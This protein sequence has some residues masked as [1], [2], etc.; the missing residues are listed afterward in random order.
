[1]AYHLIITADERTWKF[2]QPVLFIGNW[3]C[4]YDRKKIWKKIDATV[5]SRYG[6]NQEQ[7]QS[8]H[9]KARI[10]EELLFPFL[11]E[12][13]NNY[14]EKK[15]S[16]RF[17]KI[18][19]G[20][21]FRRYIDFIVYQVKT[22]EWCFS[23]Y[24]ITSTTLLE[25]KQYNL[26]PLNSLEAISAFN[27]DRWKNLLCIELIKLM[28]LP[29]SID[30]ISIE[31]KFETYR[32]PA[33]H[34][35]E[36][37]KEQK[38]GKVARFLE[39]F[40][41]KQ[42]AFIIKSYLPKIDTLKLHLS[43][44]QMPQ[45]Y[46]F[47]NFFPKNKVDSVLRCN[48]SKQVVVDNTDLLSKVLGSMLFKLLPVCYL[49]GFSEL[50]K[51]MMKMPWPSEP[52]F[53]FTSNSFDFN[54]VF[55]LWTA[56]KVEEGY[57][58]I[59][60]QHGNNYGT[61]RYMNPSI[62]EITADKFLTW[63]WVDGLAQHTP[64]FILKKTKIK[65]EKYNKEGGL[66]L[67]EGVREL[68][69]STWDDTNGFDDYFKEQQD[70]VNGL[71]NKPKDSLVI[72]LHHGYRD[73]RCCEDLRWYDFDKTLKIETGRVSIDELIGQCRLTVHSYDSTGILEM[74]AQ[75]MP[76]IAFWQNDFDHLRESAKPYYQLLLDVGIIHLTP[77][78]ATKKINDI[79]DNVED[80]W[81]QAD[82]QQARQRF[83]NQYA[84][85]SNTPIKSLKTIFG[86]KV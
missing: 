80:W 28:E 19:L 84:Q 48:L 51:K 12:I 6:L 26:S 14:H 65:K 69:I 67:I 3:C 62:E 44:W 24:E 43:L 36:S 86:E 57:Q 82:V 49:E 74:L 9:K 55:K 81:A 38:S 70:F 45:V 61:H 71:K 4:L 73:F 22:L 53:I 5:A 30:K 20:H 78:S 59:T 64:S 56:T 54:E 34:T 75:N 41:K 25:S 32:N 66:L 42:D 17:W 29:V 76:T 31:D 72:R 79:W 85:V 60:G 27:E 68:N 33:L 35:E 15:Y 23:S 13:L 63:G 2:N 58:Y 40:V 46:K 47:Y 1:M 37:V 39:L 10:L 11:C 7:K 50:R 83:C 52:K 77:E 18:L 16:L 8:D 21:W